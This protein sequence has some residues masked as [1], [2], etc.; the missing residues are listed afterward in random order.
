MDTIIAVPL[1]ILGIALLYKGADFLVDG[2]A[3]TALYLGV[4]KIT[5]AVTIIAYGTSAP[6]AGTSIIAALQSQQ[7]IS[8]GTIVG[9][10]I[11]NFL[12]ILG[13]CSIISS[14][15]THRRII[16]REM[17]M[18]LGV[19]ALLAAT[20]LV[21]RITWLVGVIFLV[22]FVAYMIYIL[23]VASKERKNNIEL[24]L[25]R[26]NNIKKYI[27]LV[28]LGLLGV[29]IGAKLLVDS[30]VAI[31][32]ALSV[33][34]VVI[35]LSVVSIGTSL[36]ELAV[37]LLSAKKKEFDISV[38]NVVGSNIF[39]ILFI[40]GLSSIIIPIPIDVK[41]LFSI[42]FMLVISIILIP[43]LYTGYKITKIEGFL[44]LGL[45]GFYL[46]YLYLM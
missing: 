3:K 14:V 45:Y 9:S 1:F 30:S 27:S 36:P 34:T 11:T 39:N 31:A 33:P 20:I 6:E 19:S 16:K 24:N 29:I 17:P 25:G 44:L 13:L 8:L 12:L 35:A 18:M 23:K 41:S 28:V 2:S 26:D 40:I 37:S 32:Q 43:I 22:S 42:L 38:G 15:E 7:G 21:G 46:Y 5:I 10:C 4:S